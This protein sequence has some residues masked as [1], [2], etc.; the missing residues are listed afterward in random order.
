VSTDYSTGF[1]YRWPAI[2]AG[3]LA[4]SSLRAFGAAGRRQYSR[5]RS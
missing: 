2:A 1:D 4:A 3:R 5:T